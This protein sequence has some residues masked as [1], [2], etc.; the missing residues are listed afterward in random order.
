MSA[1]VAVQEGERPFGID[2]LFFS[3]TDLGGR[4][5]TG[6]PVFARVSGYAM[7]ELVGRPH[8]V[9]RHPDMP[10]VAFKLLWRYLQEGRPVAAYVKNLAEDG[11]HY[12]VVATV[13]PVEGGYLSVRF[14]PSSDHFGVVA[15]VYEQL[16]EV[17]R[18]IEASEDGGR[19]AAMEASE[20]ALGE[21]LAALGIPD[22][23][24]L[25]HTFLRAEIESRER[26]L[27]DSPA[28]TRLWSEE[29]GSRPG[30]DVAAGLVETLRA[31]RAVHARM[32]DL[33]ADVRTYDVLRRRLTDRRA[34][35]LAGEIRLQSLNMRITAARLDEGR[36]T[37]GAIARIMG[38]E[39][40]AA[41]T[42]AAA[43][44]ERGDRL[45]RSLADMGF[46][47]TIGRLQAEL[48]VYVALEML[49]AHATGGRG[50][51][52]TERCIDAL[53]P[54]VAAGLEG[55][56][57]A[58]RSLG[59]ELS[60]IKAEITSLK[61]LV[62]LLGALQM[63]GRV[64]AAHLAEAGNIVHLLGEF[65][66]RVD[67]VRGQTDDLDAAVESARVRA[68]K[69]ADGQGLAR[70]RSLLPGGGRP[71]G[72]AG[73]ADTADPADPADTADP[74]DPADPADTADPAGPA[75]TADPADP[76]DTADP[77]VAELA[78]AG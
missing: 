23:D 14:K 53:G 69:T 44:T 6:N 38:E 7:D 48:A 29:P 20:A 15:S 5:V 75:D 35:D 27:S 60:A 25:M 56:T 24:A 41:R 43:L 10:R 28:W 77:P 34:S 2:E 55:L 49:D 13:V 73:P 61:S 31:F 36:E 52:G 71:G 57:G 8:N 62:D 12:W 42:L 9:V 70:L 37:I 16:L 1:E 66:E 19:K 40:L 39:A 17:E 51:P 50:E 46:R 58:S 22:Y 18:G 74:S 76:A 67:V 4:I 59:A 21:G 78:P 26:L 72:L 68:A 45:D 65:Q 30:D 54:A 11:R 3:T 47:I 33:L 64:E 63:N 32:D